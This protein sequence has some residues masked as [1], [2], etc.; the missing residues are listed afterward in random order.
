MRSEV[1]SDN[2]PIRNIRYENLQFEL[3]S[4][5]TNLNKNNIDKKFNSIFEDLDKDNNSNID[6][7]ELQDYLINKKGVLNLENKDILQ[8]IASKTTK[9]EGT[10]QKELELIKEFNQLKANDLAYKIKNKY[11]QNTF[12]TDEFTLVYDNEGRYIGK[13]N[14]NS[15]G[16][17]YIASDSIND[18]G[19]I[20]DRNSLYR[21][22]CYYKREKQA[23]KPDIETRYYEDKGLATVNQGNKT[24]EYDLKRDNDGNFVLGKMRSKYTTEYDEYSDIVKQTIKNITDNTTTVLDK[25]ACGKKYDANGNELYTILTEKSRKNIEFQIHIYPDGHI[26]SITTN[27]NMHGN[28]SLSLNGDEYDI[29][30]CN[31]KVVVFRK[32]KETIYSPLANEITKEFEKSTADEFVKYIDKYKDDIPTLLDLYKESKGES[33]FKTVISDYTMSK[34]DRVKILKHIINSMSTNIEETG[35][36]IKDLLTKFEKEISYQMNKFGFANADYLDV[37]SEQINDRKSVSIERGLSEPNGKIDENFSQGATG[38]CWLLASIIA[39]ANSNKGAEILNDSLK[40]LK[41][42]D[43]QVT[44]KGIN[45]TYTVTKQELTNNIQMAYGDGDVRALEIAINKYFEEKRGIN[46][47]L[48]INTNSP[49]VAY[50]ILTGKGGLLESFSFGQISDDKI[51]TFNA[52]NKIITV[53][54]QKDLKLTDSNTNNDDITLLSN[55]AY[56]VVEADKEFVYLINP[57]DSGNKFKV[58]RNTFKDFFDASF[59]VNL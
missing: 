21:P 23:G 39:I 22:K 47:A 28:Y 57:H 46:N 8:L 48:D 2:Q 37:F 43:M 44:L 31:N 1:M 59:I 15:R 27:N 6:K 17:I 33:L 35:I 12:Y 52:K 24:V 7:N 38:D 25:N 3:N 32:N 18:S 29:T 51:D 56:A 49:R 54:R 53:C 40:V 42:G 26:E 34:E 19:L 13:Y 20:Y 36:S 41:N 30:F 10:K 5:E 45:K 9:P 55:H 58:S 11:F 50:K 16:E 14:N 4:S